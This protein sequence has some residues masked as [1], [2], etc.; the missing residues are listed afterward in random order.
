MTAAA[1]TVSERSQAVKKREG[2]Q[3]VEKRAWIGSYVIND[4]DEG[5]HLVL[6]LFL[7]VLVLT[8]SVKHSVLDNPEGYRS[9]R[10]SRLSETAGSCPSEVQVL[11]IIEAVMVQ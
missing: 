3:N 11:Q 10:T 1:P 7:S 6:I 8:H 4:D 5:N 2:E 9:A